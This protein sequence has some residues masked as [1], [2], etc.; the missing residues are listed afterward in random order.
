MLAEHKHA[1]ELDRCPRCFGL[2]FDHPELEAYVRRERGKHPHPPVDLKRW[3]DA[4]KLAC[5]RCDAGKLEGWR[6][7]AFFLSRCHQCLGV[8]ADHADIR[9]MTQQRPANR[10]HTLVGSVPD[11]PAWIEIPA[12]TILSVIVEVLFGWL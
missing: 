8:F 5:P 4:V 2:W 3:P 1:I 7:G 6:S 10:P 9:A 11:L 12:E